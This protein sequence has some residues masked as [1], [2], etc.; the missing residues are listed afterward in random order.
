MKIILNLLKSIENKMPWTEIQSDSS[1]DVLLVFLK[2]NV[3]FYVISLA[4]NVSCNRHRA[5][6]NSVIVVCFCIAFQAFN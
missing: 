3:L 4:V 6:A 1:R 5:E 2:F